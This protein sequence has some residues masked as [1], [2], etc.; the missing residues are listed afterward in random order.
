MLVL[1][2]RCFPVNLLRSAISGTSRAAGLFRQYQMCAALR[3]QQKECALPAAAHV[4]PRVALRKLEVEGVLPVG[5][6]VGLVCTGTGK[7]FLLEEKK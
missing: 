2:R 7:V 5:V 3:E 1:E 6:A 4:K